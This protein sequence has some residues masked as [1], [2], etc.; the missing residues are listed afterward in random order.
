VIHREVTD[1]FS[2]VAWQLVMLGHGVSKQQQHH[3]VDTLT[4]E[5]REELLS[6]LRLLIDKTASALPKHVAFLASL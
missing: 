4:A 2:S 5:Q 1:L 3:L 6:N